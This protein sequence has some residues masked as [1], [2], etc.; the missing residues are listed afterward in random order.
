MNENELKSW[1]RPA[2]YNGFQ[3]VSIPLFGIMSTALLAHKILTKTDMGVWVNF[4]VLTTFVEMFR[5]GLVR[6][7][8]I[9]YINFSEKDLHV[10]IMSSAFL[11]NLVISFIISIV[12]FST[13]ARIEDFLRS[14]GLGFILNFYACSMI[15]MVFFSHFEWLMY[16]HLSFKNLF[17]T[18]LI[19]QGS[20]FVGFLA[21][22][23]IA[24]KTTIDGL[25]YIYVGGILLGAIVGFSYMRYLFKLKFVFSK[26][27][28]K[29][30]WNYGKYVFG[31]NVSTLVLKSADQF[32]LSNITST[33]AIVASQNI[34]IRVIN[35][36][37]IPSQVA[38]DILFPKNSRPEISENRKMT[39]YYY[40]KSV[41]ASLSIIFP[42]LIVLVLFPKL[43]ILVL[44]GNEYLD[45][46]PYLRLIAF[47]IVIQVYMK[48]FGVIM[49]SSGFPHINFVVVTAIALIMV[50]FCYLFIPGFQLMGAAYALLATY[51]VGFVLSMIVLYKYFKINILNTL[52][53]CITFYPEIYKITTEVVRHLFYRRKKNDDE[54]YN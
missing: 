38:G 48:Q 17:Y 50:A 34:S 14:P 47:S 7:S 43:L 30:L 54:S 15:I 36:A 51:F 16:A 23:L 49:D 31:S 2:I 53:Y 28:I 41:G 5:G 18:Y 4:L 29:T 25:V 42:V 45:A 40:E 8:L 33:P 37:D 22:Y 21:Y 6:A 35:I 13:S 1:V 26:F 52:Q 32:L 46:V 44:A 11:L 3:K 39:K 20:T 9:K 19:R 10:K 12:L 27:W 24:G